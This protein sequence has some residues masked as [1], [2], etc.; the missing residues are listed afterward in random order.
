MRWLLLGLFACT[1]PPRK[2]ELVTAPAL[3]EVAPF[4][5]QQLETAA[6]DH[7]QLIVYVGANWCEPCRR[8][9]DDLAA[10]KLDHELGTVRLL[11]FDSDRDIEALYRAGY[12]FQN[13]PMFAVPNHDGT[14]G[15]HQIEGTSTGL[16]DL[17][18]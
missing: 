15:T 17:V 12:R 13:I 1:P 18:Q 4:V 7:K 9:R 3:A 6:H 10:G 14:G 16:H 8:F 11:A 5:A 2:V